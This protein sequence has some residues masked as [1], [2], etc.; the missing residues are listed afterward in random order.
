MILSNTILL[1]FIEMPAAYK[2]QQKYHENLCNGI[3]KF[4]VMFRKYH[5]LKINKN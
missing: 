3:A 2:L 4:Q 5:F 1:N